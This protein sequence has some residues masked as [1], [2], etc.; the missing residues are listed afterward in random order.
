MAKLLYYNQLPPGLS[1]IQSA[2]VPLT[3]EQIEAAKRAFGPD[4]IPPHK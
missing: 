4:W 1:Q 3:P 2:E